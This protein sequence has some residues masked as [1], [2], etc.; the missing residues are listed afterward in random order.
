MNTERT[1]ISHNKGRVSTPADPQGSV[2]MM[3]IR[4][5]LEYPHDYCLIWPFARGDNGY[6]SFGRQGK[7]IYTHRYICE[8]V[9]GPPPTPEHQ[10]AHSCGRGHEGCVN[11]KHLSW[12][13]RA[14]N[15]LDRRE[16]GTENRVW[17]K[18]TPDDVAEIR[19]L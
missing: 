18:L 19:R 7:F 3:W 17:N 8:L 5:H 12:K 15:Q 2:L 9:K 11:P 6:G 1:Q 14:E 16:H 4:D 10:A 13:T